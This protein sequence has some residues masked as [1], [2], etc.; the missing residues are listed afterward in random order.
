MAHSALTIFI[1]TTKELLEIEHGAERVQL[2]DKLS[3]LSSK[4][5][6]AEGL[7]MLHLDIDSV[8]SGLYGRAVVS[9]QRLDK[10]PLPPSSF[11]VGDEIRLYAPKLQFTDAAESST[12]NGVVSKMSSHVVEFVCSDD[13]GLLGDPTSSFPPPLRMD[14]LANDSTHKKM[15]QA[16]SDLESMRDNSSWPLADLLFNP[17]ADPGTPEPTAIT[18]FNANLNTSQIAAIEHA[19]GSPYLAAIHGPPGTGKTTAVTELILQ[20]VSRGQR[21]LVCAP[22]NVAVDNILEKL[23][24]PIPLSPHAPPGTQPCSVPRVVRLGHPARVSEHILPYCLEALITSDDGTEIVRDVRREMDALRRSMGKAGSGRDR[25]QRKE[26]ALEMKA[27]RKEA[28]SRE[29][30]VVKQ[31]IAS[32]QVV[33]ATCIGASNKL[34]KS[35]HSSQGGNGH[36][37][38]GFDLV[39]ID[40]AAQALEASCWVAMLHSRKCVLAGDH[41]QLP[42]TVKSSEALSRGLGMTLFERVVTAPTALG[43][44]GRM[45][46]V[47]YRMNELICSWASKEMYNSKLRSDSSVAMHTLKTLPMKGAAEVAGAMTPG[48]QSIRPI[49]LSDIPVALLIDTA[50]C[51]MEED[52]RPDDSH[53]ACHGSKRASHRNPLEADV[54]VGHVQQL[55]SSGLAPHQ[56][57]VITPY[58]GQLE[59]LREKLLPAHPGLEVRTVDGFQ[60]GEKEAIVISFVRSNERRVVGFLADKRRIN[61]AVTRAR[62][63]LAIICDTDTCCSDPF[64]NS[65]VSHVSEHGEHRCALDASLGADGGQEEIEEENGVAMEG[66]VEGSASQFPVKSGLAAVQS[67]KPRLSVAE[68]KRQKQQNALPGSVRGSSSSQSTSI[69]STRPPRAPPKDSADR[70]A[71][72]DAVA[73]IVRSFATGSDSPDITSGAVKFIPPSTLTVTPSSKSLT[74]RVLS[75]PAALNA[76]QRMS[77]HALCEELGLEHRSI[78]EAFERYIEISIPIPAA[79]TSHLAHA[80]P[81]GDIAMPS[82]TS[83]MKDKPF[84]KVDDASSEDDEDEYEPP[85]LGPPAKSLP[86]QTPSN[87]KK[88]KKSKS[89]GAGGAVGHVLGSV[90]PGEL[91]SLP[92]THPSLR[93]RPN[94]PPSALAKALSQPSLDDD[95]ALLEAAIADNSVHRKLSQYRLSG[96][97]MPNPEAERAKAVLRDKIVDARLARSITNDGDIKGKI[98]PVWGTVQEK[99]KKALKKPPA[100]GLGAEP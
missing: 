58:N 84:K 21:V 42:P 63:H 33:L 27:L 94:A 59:I 16:L 19:L 73:A 61:V 90:A 23:V 64:I 9:L 44:V 82:S 4:S 43:K 80:R 15:R 45:L 5:C 22:S 18:P 11:K 72:D 17:T 75:F 25:S 38:L 93:A 56:V 83:E 86:T 77:V 71:F 51:F 52:A 79:S 6:E 28:R 98:D 32:R 99:S 88:K 68:R 70:Q 57:G 48:G 78:G 53:S 37:E 13:A 39:V 65:L 30:T 67:S 40:E 12:I 36:G 74:H 100:R 81:S 24:T 1:K 91:S 7:S 31:I 8:R 87:K 69:S 89:S 62:R 54:V 76:F 2:Q 3:S 29:E 50:G 60:G 97:P 85:T 26:Q 14:M 20:A 95:L 34:L 35:L 49:S 66:V 55:L 96:T 10:K 47:Q 41:C 46:T 92:P